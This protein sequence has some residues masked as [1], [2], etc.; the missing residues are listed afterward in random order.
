VLA[1]LIGSV[2][3]ILWDALTHDG[4]WFTER[5]GVLGMPVVAVK[6]RFFKVCDLLQ[7]LSSALGFFALVHAYRRWYLRTPPVAEPTAVVLSRPARI[8]VCGAMSGFGCVGGLVAGFGAQPFP[9]RDLGLA[10]SFIATTVVSGVSVFLAAWV[11]YSLVWHLFG[12]R[13]EPE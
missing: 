7:H 5:I 8:A 4:S 12:S 10:Q 9:P 11:A 1:V 13:L 2:S 3:H 6:G